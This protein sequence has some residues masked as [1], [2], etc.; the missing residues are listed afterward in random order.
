[1][2]LKMG[3]TKKKKSG[4]SANPDLNVKVLNKVTRKLFDCN[5]KHLTV[6]QFPSCPFT[7]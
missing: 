3:Y 7:S 5:F 1:M 2:A 6:D 4:Q